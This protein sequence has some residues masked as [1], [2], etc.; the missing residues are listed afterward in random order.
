[1]TNCLSF[2]PLLALALLAASCQPAT[3]RSAGIPPATHS[4]LG[5]EVPANVEPGGQ[6]QKVQLGGSVAEA[7]SGGWTAGELAYLGRGAWNE[8]ATKAP[9]AVRYAGEL[10]RYNSNFATVMP[11]ASLEIE[12]ADRQGGGRFVLRT[13]GGDVEE[14][15]FRRWT[16]RAPN[17]PGEELQL[18]VR[19]L[20]SGASLRVIVFVLVPATKI[21]NGVLDGYKIGRYATEFPWETDEYD[22]PPGYIKLTPERVDTEISPTFR[23]GEFVCKQKSDFPKY[24][25][26]TPRLLHKLEFLRERFLELGYPA[27]KITVMSGYRT[28]AYNR[29]LGSARLS[30]HMYGSA[31][32]IYIDVRSPK[33]WLDDLNGDG[34]VTTADITLL[35]N[36]V[37]SWTE[38]PGY[39]ERFIGGMARYRANRSHGPFLHVDIRSI[40]ARW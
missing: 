9:F 37:E 12:A 39:A 21:V 31:A 5:Q 18:V 7:V 27:D 20:T 26:L 34:R 13:F 14:V 6:R 3:P 24:L 1:M 16:W 23:L 38:A 4:G 8:S 11:G 28:P 36:V 22:P 33:D 35:Y 29:G 2:F 25:Y 32:D 15:G 17:R 30:R 40:R 10:S 19:D